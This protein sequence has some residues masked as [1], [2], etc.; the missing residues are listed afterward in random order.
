MKTWIAES[1]GHPEEVLSLIE[2]PDLAPPPADCVTVKVL[3]AGVGLP[4]LLMVNGNYPFVQQTP[5]SPGQ[6]V[7][8]IVTA[9]APGVDYAVGD[10]V[11]GLNAFMAGF[12]G[13]AEYCYMP[14]NMIMTKV[15]QGM[16]D[17]EA[18]TFVVRFQT[19]Q[20]ALVQRAKL[21]SGETLLVLGAAG[22]TGSAAVQLGKALGATVI[23]VAG[24]TEKA[25]FC[26]AQGADYVV[27]YQIGSISEQVKSL[28]GSVDVIFDPVGGH[29]AEDSLKAIGTHG[30]FLP[31]GYSSGA[32]PQISAEDM[33]LRS[34]SVVGVLPLHSS[35]EEKQ[36][37]YQQLA[38]LYQQGKLKVSVD[39][40]Y[41]F[42]DVPQ[43]L[44]ALSN[45]QMLG[46]HVVRISQ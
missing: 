24:G 7:V 3:A 2:K 32:W 37:G 46:K 43:A 13:F 39:K 21:K 10:K 26:L 33:T 17:E 6:E 15:P 25:A 9:V 38:D 19:A 4:D 36:A 1:F 14:T 41:R 18:A 27:D 16:S 35:P 23:A 8:G 29:P 44:T 12:G 22:G 11:M 31:I 28:V 40:T 20:T 45:S 42:E 5:V 34:Y 30:R